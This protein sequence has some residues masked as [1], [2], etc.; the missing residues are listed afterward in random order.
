MIERKV[1]TLLDWANEVG[2]FYGFIELIIQIVLPFCQVWSLEKYLVQN[3]FRRQRR[4]KSKEPLQDDMKLAAAQIE[5]I[6]SREK[7]RPVRELPLIAWFK[8]TILRTCKNRERN[9]RQEFFDKAQSVLEKEIDIVRLVRGHRLLRSLSRLLLSQRERQ[10]MRIQAEHRVI[11]SKSKNSASDSSSDKD[12]ACL[13]SLHDDAKEGI[14]SQRE[15][16]ILLGAGK[17]KLPR[18]PRFN[19]EDPNQSKMLLVED[20]VPDPGRTI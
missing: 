11:R 13:V 3:L 7:V 18:R 6:Q 8:D 9:K 15:I 17:A 5:A 4:T 2:G 14:L 1:Y 10:L 19:G 16:T 20:R 12:K